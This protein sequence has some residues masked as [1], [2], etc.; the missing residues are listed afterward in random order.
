MLWIYRSCSRRGGLRIGGIWWTYLAKT[1]GLMVMDY[2]KMRA[3]AGPEA[4]LA[5]FKGAMQS[6]GYSGYDGFDRHTEITTYT[7]RAYA[8]RYI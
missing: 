3:R 7:C 5:S 4:M 6:D 2:R 8:W 1:L